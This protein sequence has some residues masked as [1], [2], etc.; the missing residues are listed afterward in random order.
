MHQEQDIELVNKIEITK[1]R[2][3]WYADEYLQSEHWKAYSKII[4]SF[5]GGRCA[6]CNSDK[7]IHVHHRKYL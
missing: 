7:D 1:D 4:K 2:K 6:L 3:R 5:W